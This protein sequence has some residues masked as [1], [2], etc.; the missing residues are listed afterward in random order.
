MTASPGAHPPVDLAV[1]A[2]ALAT[3]RRTNVTVLGWGDAA[4]AHALCLRDSGVDVRIGLPGPG[5]EW[6]DA[7]AE[8][9]VVKESYEACEEADLIVVLVPPHEQGQLWQDAVAPNV[10]P[11]DTVIFGD[12]F[13]LRHGLVMPPAG[14][15]VGL[16]QP[17]G[18]GSLLRREFA[19][20]RGVPVLVAV[21]QDATGRAADTVLG[22]AGGL[23]GL[24]A[25]IVLSTVAEVADASVFG[26]AAV[27]D[28]GL[29]ELMRASWQVLVDA[30]YSPEVAYL[31]CMNAAQDALD[32]IVRHGIAGHRAGLDPWPAFASA[33][34]LL[35]DRLDDALRERLATIQ[36]GTL[37]EDFIDDVDEG[38]TAV[39]RAALRDA[40]H[41]SEPVGARLRAM[42]PWLRR[43]DES[44]G[45]RWR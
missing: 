32:S 1:A 9:F 27:T 12:G 18:S 36:D 7:E 26:A 35:G 5:R 31:S 16:V 14:V 20:G 39:A 41:P 45:R 28:G 4:A 15:D 42:M 23:G 30:G 24:R 29:H 38:G 8:G 11:G 37:A 34:P 13:A 2:H 33:Q 22:Y 6:A 3:L 44:A 25:G 43:R 17:V 19:E 40:S 10:V 21:A